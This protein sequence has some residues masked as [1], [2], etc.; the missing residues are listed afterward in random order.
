[1]ESSA[2]DSP[3]VFCFFDLR[4]VLDDISGK[5]H[6]DPGAEVDGGWD[7]EQVFIRWGGDSI[8]EVVRLQGLDSEEGVYVEAET[9]IGP[10]LTQSV[11][12]AG[13]GIAIT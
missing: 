1:M 10:P 4:D 3:S 5:P 9:S 7:V 12:K 6:L 11:N 13:I 2:K 8:C